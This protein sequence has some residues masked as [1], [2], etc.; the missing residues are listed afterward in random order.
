MAG[1]A[2]QDIIHEGDKKRRNKNWERHYKRRVKDAKREKNM[3]FRGFT[4]S[5]MHIKCS[6]L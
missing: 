6:G 4:A 1:E 5:N 2:K 3:E